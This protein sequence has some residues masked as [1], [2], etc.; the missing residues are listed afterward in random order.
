MNNFFL[1]QDP[2][3]QQNPYPQPIYVQDV[4]QQPIIRDWVGELDKML[5]GLD[6]STLE[7][8]NQDQSFVELSVS[9]QSVVQSEL[10]SLIKARLNTQPDIVDN[11]RKQI[12]MVK[13]T[14]NQTKENERKSLNELNDY[15]KNYSHLSFDE[16][17]KMKNG[18]EIDNK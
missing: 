9:L 14:T 16:Y 17:R 4:G 12:E 5:K 2:L 11:I 8:L 15:M 7:T 1:N 10:M 18:I 13:K 3:L 6:Q